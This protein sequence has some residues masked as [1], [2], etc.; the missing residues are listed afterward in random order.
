M[1]ELLMFL[2]T[3]FVGIF[4]TVC[5]TIL[6]LYVGAYLLSKIKGDVE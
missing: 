4:G 6:V 2:L 3:V 1:T 5:G